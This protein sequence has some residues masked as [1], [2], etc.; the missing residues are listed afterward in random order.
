[1]FQTW[2]NRLMHSS[3]RPRVSPDEF[4][5]LGISD[6]GLSEDVKLTVYG[7]DILSKA[8]FDCLMLSKGDQTYA[9]P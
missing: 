6:E 5:N 8:M 1:M 9:A 7:K 4:T 2:T 3:E